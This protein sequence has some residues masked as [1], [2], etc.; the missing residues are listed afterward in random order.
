MNQLGLKGVTCGIYNETGTWEFT[1]SIV[2]KNIN[3]DFPSAPFP[4]RQFDI[5][6]L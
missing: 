1:P 6:N 2:M 4:W 5:L 3:S